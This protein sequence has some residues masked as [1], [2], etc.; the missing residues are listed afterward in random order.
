MF[1][2]NFFGHWFFNLIHVLCL[3]SCMK[4]SGN[5]FNANKDIL[6]KIVDEIWEINFVSEKFYYAKT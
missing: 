6:E 5:I 1:D 2:N 4:G 3:V